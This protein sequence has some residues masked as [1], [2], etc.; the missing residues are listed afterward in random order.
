[1]AKW[2]VVVFDT[3]AEL[4]AAIEAK[5]NTVA[6]YVNT[7]MDNGKQKFMLTTAT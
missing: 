2:V 4:H 6:L 1:M 5:D 7:Y 3:Q